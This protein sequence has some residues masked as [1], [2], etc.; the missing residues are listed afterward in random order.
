MW[1]KFKHYVR[2]AEI[3]QRM[4][5]TGWVNCVIR[6]DTWST[7]RTALVSSDQ[8]W[9]VQCIILPNSPSWRCSVQHGVYAA[10][11]NQGSV[12]RPVP[13]T[14]TLRKPTARQQDKNH[15]D[16]TTGAHL[17]GLPSCQTTGHTHILQATMWQWHFYWCYAFTVVHCR[18]LFHCCIFVSWVRG[19]GCQC[20]TGICCL[21]LLGYV[22][23]IRQFSRICSFW[24]NRAIEER[25]TAGALFGPTEGGCGSYANGTS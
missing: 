16:V 19:Q 10:S 2:Y 12:T 15:R 18:Y 4:I 14:V 25:T 5:H 20:F 21:H 7:A 17:T 9:A 11:N 8:T 24:F 23:N 22:S 1:T 13:S 3:V 6:V